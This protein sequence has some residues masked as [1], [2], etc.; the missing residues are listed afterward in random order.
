MASDAARRAVLG[1]ICDSFAPGDGGDLPAASALG[2]VDTVTELLGR[3]PR[4]AERRQF[5]LLMRVWDSRLFGALNG[6]GW[7]KFSQ[8]SP[9]D[10]ERWLLGMANSRLEQKRALFQALKGAAVTSYYLTPGPTG[11]NPVWDRIGIPPAFGPVE[12]ARRGLSPQRPDADTTV[13]CDVVVIGSGAGGGTAAAVLARAGL[14]VV[15]LE[16]GEYYDDPDFGMGEKEG[17]LKLYAPGPAATAEGQLGLVAGTALGGGT[18]VNWTTSFRTPDDVREEWA[19]L[20]A[21]QFAEQEYTD[22]L[23][24]VVSR[25]GVTMDHSPASHRD[26]ILERGLRKLDWHVEPLPRNVT[27]C[28]AGIEC[29]RC[30]FGCRIGA[31][32][33][34]VKTW[35]ADAAEA[36][37]RLFVG[38]DVRRIVVENGSATGVEA[39]TADGRSVWVRARAVVVAAGA[40]QTPALLRRSG[41]GNRAIGDFL[42]LHPATAV[43]GVFDEDIRP[44]EGGLQTRYSEQDRDLD[45]NGY[46][47]IYETGPM[48]PGMSVGFQA[49]TG[50]AAHRDRMLKLANTVAVGVITRD[51]DHG[52]V[53]TDRKGEAVVRYRLS[54]RDAAHMHTGIVNAASILE[55][56]GAQR[57]FSGHQAGVAYE[58]GVQGSH[59]EFTA[60]AAAAGYAPGRCSMGALHIMGSA[61]MGGSPADSATNPDGVTWDVPNIVVADGSCFPTA[62]GVNPMVS[63][64][65]IA[66]MNAT[67]LAARLT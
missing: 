10:R 4:A 13:R 56:A 35:L 50:A 63:I 34:V 44:W 5:E 12:G 43:F 27:N 47:V 36:G 37:A 28:D 23:D 51:R 21:R 66:H 18:V 15:V 65:A 39:V 46:G 11:I 9:E 8:L 48:T 32:Q 38:T 53:E 25:L 26:E 57:I 29:G 30:G 42:R 45:G 55:A 6:A 19:G 61:R 41:L 40:V 14:D 2:V 33:S 16:R 62:S 60:Q 1:I 22:S 24:A 64:E 17:L 31:K 58:P 7:R 20:G 49:W 3:N 54:A 59:E 52:S 67:R